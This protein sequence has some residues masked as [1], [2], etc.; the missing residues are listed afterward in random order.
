MTSTNLTAGMCCPL[1]H[2]EKVLA[3]CAG[4]PEL[5]GRRVV[6]AGRMVSVVRSTSGR[7]CHSRLRAKSAPRERKA[8]SRGEG[9]GAA[10]EEGSGECLGVRC[11]GGRSSDSR[12]VA[13]VEAELLEP[14]GERGIHGGESGVIGD[15]DLLRAVSLAVIFGVEH[16]NGGG[17]GSRLTCTCTADA[18]GAVLFHAGVGA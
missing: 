10:G 13:N 9:G 12:E 16:K 7:V 6:P 18:V 14:I 5:G 3:S 1:Y 8:T 4:D 11:M 2:R 15:G 17:V